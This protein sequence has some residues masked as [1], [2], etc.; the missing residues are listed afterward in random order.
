MKFID[1]CA[2][3]LEERA[4][5]MVSLQVIGTSHIL[6]S[7]GIKKRMNAEIPP[8]FFCVV[9]TVGFYQ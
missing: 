3:R 8:Y 9:D 4:M 6:N 7:T 5:A 2:Y 1:F